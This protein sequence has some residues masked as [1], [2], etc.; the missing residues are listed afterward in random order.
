MCAFVHGYAHACPVHVLECFSWEWGVYMPPTR[1][2]D[3][4]I[5]QGWKANYANAIPE[6]NCYARHSSSVRFCWTWTTNSTWSPRRRQ[7]VLLAGY[8]TKP[9]SKRM[10]NGTP[11]ATLPQS[12]TWSKFHPLFFLLLQVPYSSLGCR[13]HTFSCNRWLVCFKISYI[14]GA[15]NLPEQCFL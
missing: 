6:K 9:S 8:I 5:V 7:S 15:C 11:S 13:A 10:A 2:V 1:P 3:F 14:S 12:S 4:V